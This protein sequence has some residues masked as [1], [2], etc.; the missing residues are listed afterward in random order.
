MRKQA[1]QRMPTH[2]AVKVVE[3]AWQRRNLLS[4]LLLPLSWL[5]RGLFALR[6]TLY[7]TGVLK[8]HDIE[9]PVIVVGNL[10]VGGTGKTPLVIELAE[11]LKAMGH[12]PGIVS[13]G[14]GGNATQLPM[15]VTV[16]S[17]AAQVGDEALLLAERTGCPVMVDHDR[18]RAAR[19][20]LGDHSKYSIDV[21][22]S[23]DGLQHYA[24]GRDAEIVVH[25][26]E[27][28]AQNSRL[29]PAGPWREPISG[30]NSYDLCALRDENYDLSLELPRPVRRNG[31]P[32]EVM[33]K[34]VHAIAGIGKPERF[35][36]QLEAAGYSI[37]RHSYPDHH[38]YTTDDLLFD[39][40]APVLMTE[41]DAVKCRDF[42][43]EGL[44]YVPA[45]AQLSDELSENL[46]VLLQR[47]IN[48]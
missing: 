44:Y 25:D 37:T 47:V 31:Q 4:T 9:V 27:V 26:P 39:S 22:I 14:Y 35:F 42:D 34:R 21:I 10:S 18:A 45:V 48:S 40:A 46:S 20:L 19:E 23:D 2:F 3:N 36:E 30:L 41:K 5:Y 13:R 15:L 32:W 12:A 16:D 1:V 38:V 24:L 17:V 29:F 43:M 6:K 33:N 11:R 28:A 7:A 8:T